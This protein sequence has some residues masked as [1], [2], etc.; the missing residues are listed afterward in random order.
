M[1]LLLVKSRY[2]YQPTNHLYYSAHFHKNYKDYFVSMAQGVGSVVHDPCSN[3]RLEVANSVKTVVMQHLHTDF[4]IVRNTIP[5]KEC[6]ISPVV[7]F[8]TF[9]LEEPEELE[10]NGYRYKATIPHYLSKSYNLSCVKVRFG[11][12]SSPQSLRMLRNGRSDKENVPYYIVNKKTI[13]IYC[14][15]FCEV[16]CTSMKKSVHPRF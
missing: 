4:Q 6:L 13:K 3:V 8:H 12:I 9:E 1:F 15:H 5:Q 10:G 11:D 16:V 7:G 2:R 14:N